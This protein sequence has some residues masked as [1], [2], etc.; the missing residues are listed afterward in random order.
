MT[1]RRPVAFITGASRGIGAETAVALA[2]AGY[3]LAITAR[4]MAGGEK[5]DYSGSLVP[6]P[7]SLEATADAVRAA[8]GEALCLRSDLT[9]ADSVIAAARVALAQFGNIDLL[10]NNGIYQGK[11]IMSPLLELDSDGMQTILQGNLISP[12]LLVKEILP[13]MQANGGGTIIN[14]ISATAYL[15]PHGPADRGGWGFAYA[16]SKAALERM[17]SIIRVE[18][19]DSGVRALNLE[20]GTVVT[21][22]MRRAGI[23]E[24]VLKHY[25][26]CTPAAIASV[27]VWLMQNEPKSEWLPAEILHAPAIAKELGLLGVASH[28]P[29][30]SGDR[31]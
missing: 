12:W 18:H 8:G 24:D 3:D 29:D 23:D 10:F 7:G 15:Q 2:Q 13:A 11:E 30:I 21:E 26:P 25:K 27:V 28:L 4:T 6:L 20:P 31:E 16:A 14:M 9:D 1:E 5:N 17:A 22:V 19:P